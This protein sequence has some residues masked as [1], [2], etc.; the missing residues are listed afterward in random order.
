MA[1]IS[2]SESVLRGTFPRDDVIILVVHQDSFLQVDAGIVVGID[3]LAEVDSVAKLL[4]EDW[5]A[6][7]AGDLEQEKTGVGLGK[8][9]VRR[10]VLVQDLEDEGEIFTLHYPH[11]I[12]ILFIYSKHYP[13]II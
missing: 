4:F 13:H 2:C 3:G 6:G 9:V 11:T 8:V 5:L 7:V 12:H 10:M 1:G